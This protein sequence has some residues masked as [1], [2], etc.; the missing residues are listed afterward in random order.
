ML[1]RIHRIKKHAGDS[2]RSAAHIRGVATVKPKDYEQ[3]GEV[4]ASGIYAAWAKMRTVDQPLQT[5]DIL[6]DPAG[7]L[8]IAKYIGFEKANWWTPETKVAEE[9]S[10]ESQSAT[11]G[12]R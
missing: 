8:Y 3:V 2:F 7:T 10:E 11:S 9:Q 1:F 5:G 12:Q 6:E 4:D